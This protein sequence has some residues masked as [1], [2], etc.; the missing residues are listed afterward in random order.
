MG[1][2]KRTSTGNIRAVCSVHESLDKV[3]DIKSQLRRGKDYWFRLK[4]YRCSY[5]DFY[6]RYSKV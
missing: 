1:Q 5:G 2:A 4:K 3:V 6:Q